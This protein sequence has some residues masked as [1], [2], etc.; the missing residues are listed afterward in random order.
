MLAACRRNCCFAP[1]AALRMHCGGSGSA[2]DTGCS[3]TRKTFTTRAGL[4]TA[5][6]PCPCPAHAPSCNRPPVAV[7]QWDE[8]H[9]SYNFDVRKGKVF[10]EWFRGGRTNIAYNCLDRH[11]AEGRG[12]QTAILWE[13]N[14]PGIDRKLTYQ[15]VL[16]DVCRLVRTHSQHGDVP[17][18]HPDGFSGRPCTRWHAAK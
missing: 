15:E 14:D 10:T 4:C 16:D 2:V 1:C 7:P 9:F 13:G 17:P 18:A 6:L 3:S 5:L 11:V 8:K 12:G